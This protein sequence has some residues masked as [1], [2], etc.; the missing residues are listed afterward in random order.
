MEQTNSG[1]TTKRLAGAPAVELAGTV[2]PFPA[3]FEALPRP[4]VRRSA[5]CHYAALRDG[6]VTLIAVGNKLPAQ[7][8][9][10]G[11]AE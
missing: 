6:I 3:D 4:Q 10:A 8:V 2:A 7:C 1:T 5:V 11:A 9:V